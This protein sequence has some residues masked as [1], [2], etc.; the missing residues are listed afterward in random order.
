MSQKDITMKLRAPSGAR[1]D[2]HLKV[3]DDT[4]NCILDGIN[5]YFKSPDV[6][7]SDIAGYDRIS[8][9]FRFS[10][11]KVHTVHLTNPAYTQYRGQ[12]TR[13]YFHEQNTGAAAAY[14]FCGLYFDPDHARMMDKIPEKKQE[15]QKPTLTD[16]QK[17]TLTDPKNLINDPSKL[18]L[19][20]APGTKGDFLDSESDWQTRWNNAMQHS[21]DVRARDWRLKHKHQATVDFAIG[22]IAKELKAVSTNP[23][24]EVVAVLRILRVGFD[25]LFKLLSLLP[26]EIAATADRIHMNLEI[27]SLSIERLITIASGMFEILSKFYAI[28]VKL[29]WTKALNMVSKWLDNQEKTLQYGIENGM[30]DE[31]YNPTGLEKWQV[32]QTVPNS[33]EEFRKWLAISG[34]AHSPFVG[35]AVEQTMRF[36]VLREYQQRTGVGIPDD[37]A[38]IK[39]V[40]G[41]QIGVTVP[42]QDAMDIAGQV[43]DWFLEHTDEFKTI[44]RQIHEAQHKE[45]EALKN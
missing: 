34:L 30:L 23:I 13:P 8:F 15:E 32:P 29:D 16:P 6:M 43:P 10:D 28:A 12:D 42:I 38:W 11:G 41:N 3:P 33:P 22:N 9:N 37:Y 39:Y 5:Q 24:S 40:L 31:N 14:Q 45:L 35:S 17:P 2:F 4:P 20:D 7:A 26:E 1:R 36:E 25:T 27:V 18:N 19:P 21:R 44:G